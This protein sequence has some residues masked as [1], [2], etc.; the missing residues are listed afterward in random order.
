MGGPNAI[1]IAWTSFFTV[2]LLVS[3][4]Q[5]IIADHDARSKERAAKY[6]NG[7]TAVAAGLARILAW[8]VL[9]DCVAAGAWLTAGSL[10]VFRHYIQ[11]L[12]LLPEPS[13]VLLLFLGA[14]AFGGRVLV[15]AYSR[16]F[17]NKL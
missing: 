9:L 5:Y 8:S 16:H 4:W 12:N 13:L 10:S 17:V 2:V 3:I 1:E 11:S 14:G 7:D 15:R 6:S